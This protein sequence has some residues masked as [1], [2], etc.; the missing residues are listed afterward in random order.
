M[1]LATLSE[2]L[3]FHPSFIITERVVKFG[4][5]VLITI[6]APYA[7]VQLVL[8][9]LLVATVFLATYIF[10]RPPCK[11]RKFALTRVAFLLMAG[12]TNISSMIAI[13][14]DDR[15]NWTAVAVL[16]VGWVLIVLC[17]YV[18]YL[19]LQASN[20]SVASQEFWVDTEWTQTFKEYV[21]NEIDFLSL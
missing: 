19:R 5:L 17:T 9:S 15:S 1:K 18:A 20:P 12:H 3:R 21:R 8:V 10:V 6:F 11:S 16:F 4:V 2:V 13:A 7:G 14:V